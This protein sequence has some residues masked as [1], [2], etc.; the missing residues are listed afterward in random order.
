MGDLSFGARMLRKN[1]GFSLAAILTLALGV[2]ANTAI[3]SVVK[4][5]LLN[6][7]PFRDPD[8]LVVIATSGADS[9]RPVT[10]DY[11]TTYDLRSRVRSFESMSLYRQWRS[12]LIGEGDPELVNGLRVNFDYFQ[13]LG[14][15]MQLG[16]TFLEEEDRLDRWNKVLILSHALWVRRFGGDPGIIG[17]TI[18]LNESSFTVVGVLP[19]GFRPIALGESEVARDIFAPLGY[20]LSFRDACRGCQHLRLAARLKPGVPLRSAEAE[21]NAA[22]RGIVQEHAKEYDPSLRAIVTP[23]REQAV[24][25]V[26]TALWIVT[27]AVGFVLLIACANVANLLL[28]RATGRGK[29]IALRTALGAARGRLVRQLLTESLMLALAGGAGGIGLAYAAAAAVLS[30]APREIPRIGEV[31]IDLAVLCFGLAASVFSGV[32]FGLAPA[33]R[34]SRIDLTDA[35]KDSGRSTSGR[36]GL[37]NALVVAEL[38]LAFVLAVGAGLLA[39]SFVRVMNVDPGFDPHN[40]LTLNTYVY[41]KRYQPDEAGV[42][43]ARQVLERLAA[44]PGIESAAFVSVLPLTSFDRVLVHVQDRLRAN[45]SEGPSADRYSISPDYFRVMRIPVKRGRV[46]NDQDRA[47][48]PPVAL[49]SETCARTCFGGDDPVGKHVQFGGRDDSKPWMTVVGVVGDVH[50]YGLDRAAN[51]AV[52]LPLAQNPDFSY[53]LAARTTGDPGRMQHAVRDAFQAVD[54]TQPVF[55]VAPMD[56]Y[57]RASTAQRSFTLVLL[58]LFAAL[59]LALAAVGIYGVISYAVSLRTREIGIRM[60]VGAGRRDVVTIV[61]KQALGLA[62]AGLAAGFATSLALTRVLATL[63]YEVRP[64]DLAN[65]GMMAAL[66]ML[67]VLA[68]SYLPARRACRVDPMSALRCE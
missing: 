36:G 43:Y 32:V 45:A 18:Q 56:T 16:R 27:G 19:A 4:A 40:V 44:T 28:A 2:G 66:L 61:V 63:L 67:V 54:K 31:K 41:A 26:S 5:V 59:A 24:G 7:L 60:A 38:G 6:Q 57:L 50:Q 23:I 12:A 33:L 29:E 48:A 64:S 13:T 47:G 51:M 1:P 22:L 20:E 15:N 35:L 46:F 53:M 17:R 21:L 30:A 11:T 49:V 25:R 9:I 65:S 14:V 39:K 52:Y 62:A 37:R 55:D 8:S 34:A 68:A 10:V 42:S 58:A 3:F